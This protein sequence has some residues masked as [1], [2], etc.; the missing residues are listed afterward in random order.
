VVLFKRDQP[1]LGDQIYYSGQAV[2]IARGRWFEDPFQ[3]DVYAADHVP[4]TSLSVAVVSWFPD[5]LFWQ[6]M[7]MAIYGTMVVAAI[8]ALVWRLAGRSTGLIATALAAL[9]ANFWMNDGLI[10]AETLAAGGVVG[11]LWCAYEVERSPRMRN[12][13][14]LGVAVGI[15]T[16]ARAELLLL[17]PMVAIPIVWM[18]SVRRSRARRLGGSMAVVLV[19][20][21]VLAPWV[22]R[23]LLR[24]E[25]RTLLSTQDGLTLIGA[26]CQ[27][28]YFG[29]GIGFWSLNCGLEVWGD[30][31][32]DQSQ[33]S[34]AMRAEA[35]EFISANL[36]RVPRVV[37]ARLGRGLS[38]WQPEAM[39]NLNTGEGREILASRIG[40]VQF[41]LLAPLAVMGLLLWPIARPRWP[42]VSTAA[43]SLV[44]IIAMYGIP[45]FRI[46]AE[47]V[48]VIGAAVAIERIVAA[49]N[50]PKH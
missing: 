9:Y 22:G 33:R 45:R 25:E 37:L 7:L 35:V 44:M 28:T 21:A 49:T 42:L 15:T 43:I 34:V 50:P 39:A 18:S 14:A 41:W 30:P 40:Y 2:T 1:V 3:A 24:F 4:L 29:G 12:L 46:A 13:I 27:D 10:M 36:D 19:V 48:I 6:R 5:P 16:L 38:V 32:W 8:G 26:N 47:V 11:V 20:L 23:N 31:T 17:L